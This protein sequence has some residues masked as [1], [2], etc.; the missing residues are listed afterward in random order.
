MGRR[1]RR[2]QELFL[3]F[4]RFER[5]RERYREQCREHPHLECH[6][7]GDEGQN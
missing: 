5:F 4:L 6:Q 3:T 2:S 1:F 7:T